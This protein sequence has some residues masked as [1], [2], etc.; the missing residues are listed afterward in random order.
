[1][2]K[3][4]PILTGFCLCI[5]FLFTALSPVF[6][7]AE[8]FP[9][10]DVPYTE[11]PEVNF[12]GKTDARA[13]QFLNWTLQ[14]YEWACYV[15]PS[16]APGPTDPLSTGTRK[17]N[18]EAN[19]LIK[20]WITIRNIVYALFALIVLATAFVL[21]ATRGK[22]L[23]LKRFLPRFVAVV[24]LVTLS[25]SLIQ[26]IYTTVDIIQGF[27]LT[28]QPA[29]P[30][31]P[32]ELISAIDLLYVG[33][34][35]EYFRGLRKVHPYFD[36]AVFVNLLLARLTAVTYYAM[37]GVLII[38]K[39]ILWFFIVLSPV[40]PILLLYYPVRN[41]AKIWIGEFFRWLL[42]APLFTIFLSGLVSIWK[43][44]TMNGSGIPLIFNFAN[45]N[46]SFTYPT[47][48][49]VLLGGPGQTVTATNNLN[50]PDTFALYVVALIMLWVVILLPFILLQIFL[51]YLNNFSFEESPAM[52]KL[53]NT[54]YML[55]NKAPPVPIN[56]I[57]SPGST[58]MAKQLPFAKYGATK[59]LP[60]SEEPPFGAAKQMP[61]T[62]P[63]GVAM[64]TQISNPVS[65]AQASV[66]AEIL[67]ATNISLPTIRDIASFER[68]I[69]SNK[70][71]TNIS[72]THEALRGLANPSTIQNEIERDRFVQLKERLVK[73]SQAGNNVAN[74]ILSAMNA[75]SSTSN[76]SQ[77]SNQNIKQI[78][79]LRNTLT[80]IT[81]PQKIE[82]GIDKERITSLHDSLVK[83][84]EKG[85]ISATTIL[86]AKENTT[87]RELQSIKDQ[88][89][90]ESM[91]GNS[92]STAL[93][94]TSFTKEHESVLKNV[95][96]QVAS[97]QTA[98]GVDKERITSL[99]DSLVKESEKGNTLATSILSTKE[100]A[101]S[102]E[103][104]D[105]KEKLIEATL[106]GNQS[107]ASILSTAITRIDSAS[108]QKVM[109]QLANPSSI[110][111]SVSKEKYEKVKEKLTQAGGQ[112]NQFAAN[113]LS[114][115]E[116]VSK[117]ETDLNTAV[118]TKEMESVKAQ[119]LDAK[120]KGE[121]LATDILNL[122][123]A[124]GSVQEGVISSESNRIQTVSVEDYEAVKKMWQENYK[125]MEVPEG[126]MDRKAWISD[127]VSDI[128]NILSLLDSND[129]EKIQ[130]GMR[131]VGNVLPFLMLGGFSQSEIISYLKAKKEAGKSI[132][133]EINSEDETLVSV[134]KH[135]TT[136]AAMT[137]A[138]SID[139][140]S[141]DESS[142]ASDSV[143][144]SKLNVSTELLELVNLPL[145]TI[146]DLMSYEVA[147]KSDKSDVKE[148]LLRLKERLRSIENPDS[149]IDGEE[150]NKVSEIKNDLTQKSD[151]GDVLAKVI[152]SA[153]KHADESLPD[154][155]NNPVSLFHH[156]LLELVKPDDYPAAKDNESI[157]KIHDALITEVDKKN[158]L[159]D[160]VLMVTDQTSGDQV[161]E[162]RSEIKNESDAGNP[163]AQLVWE[164]APKESIATAQ[165]GAG[166]LMLPEVNPVQVV[167]VNDYEAVRGMWED[168]YRK[169]DV[170]SD[171]S[172][173]KEWLMNESE[174]IRST[175]MLLSSNDKEKVQDGLHQVSSLLTFVLLGGF[176]L[177]EI[178]TYLDAKL[179]AANSVL[180]EVTESGS[181]DTLVDVNVVKDT[182]SNDKTQEVENERQ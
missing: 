97:P 87:I 78:K 17:C 7:A 105:M 181:T 32:R 125:D 111:N 167:D 108:T 161:Q 85:N 177:S 104:H 147:M 79:N 175:L 169:S 52:A 118:N 102:N 73:E 126:T 139:D 4:L 35:Y 42:Y 120:E 69:I 57:P 93:L 179:N 21:M 131:E 10:P 49:N 48:T 143:S 29:T 22:S 113:M 2:K 70:E 144:A 74:S 117:E 112:G 182:V 68:Q 46:T 72:K 28:K 149:V 135:T 123:T 170:P 153:A 114:K 140:S 172:G 11:D 157:R 127:E 86:A 9:S 103:I 82:T 77:I 155:R 38:R 116:S 58:G 110:T 16:A 15:D 39:I 51:D 53:I 146:R 164:Y 1:M 178:T 59:S 92:T 91:Q 176:S 145:P 129:Q 25:Y 166:D 141:D 96:T 152:L 130:E 119:L 45:V 132:I 65:M 47:A 55:L 168:F 33:W 31:S 159:A 44:P 89:T 64:Q 171:I 50:T 95:L 12:V 8:P 37:T 76:V 163:L 134:E 88:L 36:E 54:S 71:S 23:T 122:F 109:Q 61:I 66:N 154:T 24:L 19:P 27:F 75:V 124:E 150:K 62:V 14:N 40:F 20:F 26:F 60:I 83:E 158:I 180:R 56:P 34:D 136:Q 90:R 138:A 80:N 173:K 98:S 3:I 99:H 94:A 133:D 81:N 160:R 121:P 84:S 137:Q 174:N 142:L 101:T 107:A 13:V 115:M 156:Y 63:M 5:V 128:D 162:L 151:S 106:Q 148:N 165:E 100:T 41:T 6:A 43:T 18:N 30:S 67:N